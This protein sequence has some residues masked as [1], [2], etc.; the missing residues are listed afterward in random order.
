MGRIKIGAR[1][2]LL[3]T[4]AVR[5]EFAQLFLQETSM[6]MR[7][8]DLK[9]CSNAVT[10]AASFDNMEEAVRFGEACAALV[11]RAAVGSSEEVQQTAGWMGRTLPRLRA[12]E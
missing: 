3:G 4:L 2:P 8:I 9:V 7:D 6:A 11:R 10:C 1:G 5:P 12:A